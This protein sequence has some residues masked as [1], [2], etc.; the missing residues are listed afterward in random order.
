MKVDK[1]GTAKH[2]G[3]INSRLFLM[4]LALS[5]LLYFRFSCTLR[6]KILLFVDSAANKYKQN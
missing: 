5:R 4:M 1:S 3:R 2:G 6:E